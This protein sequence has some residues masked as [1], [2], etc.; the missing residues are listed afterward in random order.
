METHHQS[1]N[2]K[3]TF[4]SRVILGLPEVPGMAAWLKKKGI[5]RH[6]TQARRIL[7][8]IITV[9]FVLALLVFYFFA[10]R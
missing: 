6:E 10:I 8:G 4:T 9:D 1:P 2:E 3:H 7:I 5:I